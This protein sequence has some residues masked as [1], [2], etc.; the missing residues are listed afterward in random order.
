MAAWQLKTSAE[1]MMDLNMTPMLVARSRAKELTYKVW[2]RRSLSAARQ[3]GELVLAA[4]SSP[5]V[6]PVVRQVET[7]CGC[8]SF[9]DER[10][11]RLKADVGTMA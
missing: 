7:G 2:A 11:Q 5:R 10:R 4:M 3:G 9:Y 8:S 1:K 6:A